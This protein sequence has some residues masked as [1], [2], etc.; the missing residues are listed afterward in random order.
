MKTKVILLGFL[1]FLGTRGACTLSSDPQRQEPPERIKSGEVIFTVG[2]VEVIPST[3]PGGRHTALGRTCDQALLDDGKC[4]RLNTILITSK[5]GFRS[6]QNT[7][8][9]ETLHTIVGTAKSN[10]VIR[11]SNFLDEVSP[12]LLVLLMENPPLT[13][14]LEARGRTRGKTLNIESFFL[15]ASP[16]ILTTPEE[17]FREALSPLCSNEDQGGERTYHDWIYD[18]PAILIRALQSNPDLVPHSQ[19]PIVLNQP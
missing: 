3:T 2:L 1:L 14:Y 19:I 16:F 10:M 6:E 18:L 17:T 4:D 11:C 5:Q 13:D 12:K 7:T 8:A 9:H 15:P